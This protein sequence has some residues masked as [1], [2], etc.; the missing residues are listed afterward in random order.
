MAGR[1]SVE[2]VFKAVDRVTAPVSR[3]QQ[4]VGK[5]TRSFSRGLRKVNRVIDGTVRGIKRIGGAAIKYG[6]IGIGVA[7]GAVGLLVREFSKVE[8]A[9]AAFTPLL[10]GAE[11]AK[12]MVEALNET[13]ATTPFQFENLASAANQLLPVMNG[14]IEETIRTMRLLGDTAGG[15][16]QKLDSIT[17]GVTKAMLKGKVDMESLNMIA[18]AGVPIFTELAES[19]G[20]KVSPAF[21]KMIS[22][23]KVT[24]KDLTKA[25][26]KMTSEGGKFHNGMMIAS[27]TTSGMWS[28]LKDNVS[29]TAAELG[30]VLAPTIKE[31][32]Q[33]ATKAAQRVREW[34]KSN[35]ELINTKFL[36]YVEIAKSFILGLVDAFNWLRKHKDT[37]IKVTATV[38]ALVIVLKLLG[39]VMAV[40]NLVMMANPIGLIVVAV[41]ALIAAIAAAIIW[42]DEIKAAFL[43]LPGPVKA[44]IAVLTGPIGWLI[45]AASLIYENWE[46]IKAFFGELW[47]GVVGIF[48]SAVAK[49]MA[50]VD[51]VK[52]AASTIVDTIS[53]IGSG[54]AE[55][56]GFGGDEEDDAERI[57]QRAE[58]VSPQDRTARMIEERRTT[59]SA[60]VT[61]RD[62]T[63][64]AEVT[65]GQLGTGIFLTPSG[66]F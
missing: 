21:F 9:Q 59:S 13:A 33:Q 14:N 2:S 20:T 53:S 29:L 49:I 31:L 34:V 27:Q 45:G 6:A 10:G 40:V 42:W 50:V 66:A 56:F 60:E 61:I 51:R 41:A 44:A 24:T 7:S 8:D 58:V 12:E 3:M 17:R 37:I 54:V 63:N 64:R 18:E 48:N 32:I 23:G 43:S 30:S 11:R 1:F 16:A 65:K 25:F 57:K 38:A 19:M 55:F 39:A 35:R 52:N 62:E 15:N 4:R 28:T 47:D 46:P 22:A 26:E 36:E 5:F